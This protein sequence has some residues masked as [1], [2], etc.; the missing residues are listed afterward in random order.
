MKL[1]SRIQSVINPLRISDPENWDRI[2]K[3]EIKTIHPIILEGE[4]DR[5]LIYIDSG[6]LQ[7]EDVYFFGKI[8]QMD[9]LDQWGK[10]VYFAERRRNN[11]VD[12]KLLMRD[13]SWDVRGLS[14][15]KIEEINEKALQIIYSPEKM[16]FLSCPGCRAIAY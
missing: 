15:E 4:Y 6:K 1:K 7:L 3:G 11:L 9:R 14:D 13:N 12:Q 16:R 2:V 8:G 10:E 5:T